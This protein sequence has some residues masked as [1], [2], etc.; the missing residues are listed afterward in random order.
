MVVLS[1][2]EEPRDRW[3]SRRRTDVGPT[4]GVRAHGGSEFRQVSTFNLRKKFTLKNI[5][6]KNYSFVL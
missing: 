4:G 5:K 1:G 3:K 2:T 6:I